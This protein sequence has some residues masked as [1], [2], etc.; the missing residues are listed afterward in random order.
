MSYH[1]WKKSGSAAEKE[2]SFASPK[3]GCLVDRQDEPSILRPRPSLINVDQI[4]AWR[5]ACQNTHAECRNRNSEL[6]NKRLEDLTLVDVD[7][8][9]LVTLPSTTAY[10]ALSYVWGSV[11]MLKATQSNMNE[12]RKPGALTLEHFSLPNTIRDAMNL[13]KSLGERYL[14]VDC[15]SIVQDGDKSYMDG[16]LRAMANI[17][18]SA[19]FTIVAAQGSDANAG[20]KG[21]GGSSVGRDSLEVDYAVVDL[22]SYPHGSVWASRAWTFQEALFSRRLLVL[23]DI[24]HWLCSRSVWDEPPEGPTIPAKDMISPPKRFHIGTPMGMMS[25][26]TIV[27]SL[28][29]A[30]IIADDYNQRN[31]TFE[32]DFCSAIAGATEI[33]S[34]FLP[35]GII[36]GLPTFF[37]D[38]ALLWHPTGTIT[39]RPGLP[40]WSWMGWVGRVLT[41]A[42]WAPF[43]PD[44]A[45]DFGRLGY[46]PVARLKPIARFAV[47]PSGHLEEGDVVDLSLLL[48][49][50][51]LN[52]FYEYQ[53]L[54]QS[55]DLEPLEGWPRHSDDKGTYF[56]CKVAGD[57]DR[58][59]S[60]PLPLIDVEATCKIPNAPSPDILLCTAPRAPMR[61]VHTGYHGIIQLTK[62]WT[63]RQDVAIGPLDIHVEVRADIYNLIALSEGT[64]E[65]KE[66]MSK[67]AGQDMCGKNDLW[68][69]LEEAHIAISEATGVA[70]DAE[71]IR[72]VNVMLID[73]HDSIAYRVGLGMVIEKAWEAMDPEVINF[74]LG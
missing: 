60:F 61:Q 54:R 72:F 62:E 47:A 74:R 29:L 22:D 45:G 9:S 14:W 64:V 18:A 71:P 7:S 23:H 66:L 48:V 32:S 8:Q 56:T 41:L 13:V 51:D 58:K 24:A 34:A 40:S 43:Y 25:Q 3:Y 57:G 73:W 5:R 36:H 1:D 15:L 21:T 55:S 30:Q 12:L 38:I 27:P 65:N 52:G 31:L 28:Y 67:S 70:A 42:S 11:P 37:F 69:M 39:R 46:L 17:Y 44:M 63:P 16:M 49:P 33:L 26:I 50:N 4:R 19:E 59:Y 6:L 20:L 53:D 10:V 68:K 2:R 35:G